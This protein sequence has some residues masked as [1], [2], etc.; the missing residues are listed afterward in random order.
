MI[1]EDPLDRPFGKFQRGPDNRFNDDELVEC[2]SSAVEDCAGSFGARNVPASMRAIEILGIIQSR[3]WNVAGLNEFR[4]HFG[5]KPYETFEDINSD[6]GVAGSLRHL[7]GHPDFVELYPGMVAEERKEPMA[8]GVGICPTYTISRVVLS[9]AVCL[10]RGDRHYTTEYHPRALTNWGYNEVQYDLNINHGCV[11][12]K[13]FIRAFPEH[14]KSN[15]V[16]AHYPMVIPSETEKILKDLKRAELFD[17]TRP[18]RIAKHT[19]VATTAGIKTVSESERYTANW[20]ANLS[21]LLAEGGH[22][23]SL[24]ADC[25]SH[26]SE[27]LAIHEQLVAPNGDFTTHLKSVYRKITSEL[28]SANSCRVADHNLVDIVRDVGNLAPVHVLAHMFNLPLTT[29]DRPKGIYT[30]HELYAVLSVIYTALFHDDDPVKSFP[31]RQAART[32][33]SQLGSLIEGSVKASKGLFAS[34]SKDPLASYGSG[35]IAGLSKVGLTNADIAWG[36]I[37]PIVVSSVPTQGEWFAQAV[38]FYLSPGGKGAAHLA[39]IQE[40]AAQEPSEETDA[41]LLGYALEGVRLGGGSAVVYR[42]ATAVD[43]IR[44]EDGCES[45]VQPGDKVLLN[46]VSFAI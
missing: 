43:I 17:F 11:F 31:I 7:Y 39:E 14:F 24:A 4:K 36:Q 20:H 23:V 3:K 22:K 6:P 8:P 12:Y 25:T 10:V 13:L 15:S 2:I 1:P 16:Y 41:R 32:V 26:D 33:A 19:T 21:T 40:L 44:E 9:D 34:K 30:D 5:L 35:L 29:K 37:L 38:D 27:R 18:A 45:T 46:S 28:L 42:T